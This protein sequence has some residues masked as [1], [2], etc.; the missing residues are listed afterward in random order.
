VPFAWNTLPV[1]AGDKVIS[2]IVIEA[3]TKTDTI[4]AFVGLGNYGWTKAISAGILIE[5]TEYTEMKLALDQAWTANTCSTHN[6]SNEVSDNGV[7]DVNYR[8]NH[9]IGYN[10]ADDGTVLGT[11]LGTD[12]ST[13]CS[14]DYSTHKAVDKST[15]NTSHDN[16]DHGTHNTTHYTTN[17]ASHYTG[18]NVTHNHTVQASHYTVNNA[19]VNGTI[20]TSDNY[21]VDNGDNGTYKNNVD[22][23]YN[24]AVQTN[25]KGSNQSVNNY[26]D[27]PMIYMII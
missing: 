4:R 5:A 11:H 21:T 16:D 20:Q 13:H 14:T 18:D 6:S 15:N 1:S 8:V 25:D 17:Q 12:R 26:T 23:S 22:D 24:N 27:N 3:R 9:Y 10:A 7:H 19:T 2:T